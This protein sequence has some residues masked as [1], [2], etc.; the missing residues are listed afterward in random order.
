MIYNITL[1][2]F[3]LKQSPLKVVF[4][5]KWVISEKKYDDATKNDNYTCQIGVVDSEG[6]CVSK[7]WL[8]RQFISD[9]CFSVQREIEKITT[10]N[11]SLLFFS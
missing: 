4:Q 8:T 1:F 5:F 7:L 3:W 9:N 6:P 11:I 2:R 10:N